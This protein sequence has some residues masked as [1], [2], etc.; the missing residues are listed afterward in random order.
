MNNM[1]KSKIESLDTPFIKLKYNNIEAD[2]LIITHKLTTLFT[3]HN[4]IENISNTT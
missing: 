4:L 1:N 3:T 2:K